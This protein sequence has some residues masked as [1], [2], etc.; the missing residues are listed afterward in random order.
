MRASWEKK[1]HDN[2]K[3]FHSHHRATLL[4]CMRENVSELLVYFYHNA[5]L[6]PQDL[7]FNW[8]IPSTVQQHN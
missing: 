3:T 6:K 4:K 2:I 5:K 1:S 7:N 8:I